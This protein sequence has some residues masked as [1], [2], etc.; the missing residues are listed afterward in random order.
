MFSVKRLSY[1]C[2]CDGWIPRTAAAAVTSAHGLHA[3]SAPFT[4]LL[5]CG[6]AARCARC[7]LMPSFNTVA[8]RRHRYSGLSTYG[9]REAVYSNVKECTQFKPSLS[10]FFIFPVMV[11]P[12][13]WLGA[14]DRIPSAHL[15]CGART[16]GCHSSEGV[17]RLTLRPDDDVTR[18]IEGRSP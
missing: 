13:R 2:R 11:L 9:L 6:A 18:N 8:R 3:A 15:H 10:A 12:S 17:G 1:L 16:I 14:L 7:A 4:H 5:Q